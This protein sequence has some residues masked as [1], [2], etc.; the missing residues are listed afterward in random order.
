MH[1][2]KERENR[3][4][5]KYLGIDHMQEMEDQI[6][7]MP[8]EDSPLE[9]IV[10]W[11]NIARQRVDAHSLQLE[12]HI[13]GISLPRLR[14][15]VDINRFDDSQ[16]ELLDKH[17]IGL[18]I[19]ARIS[20]MSERWG[21]ILTDDYLIDLANSDHKLHDLWLTKKGD[22]VDRN[23]IMDM[24]VKEGYC[25]QL[26]QARLSKKGKATK[27]D[28]FEKMLQNILQKIA[29]GTI[30]SPK[31][32]NVIFQAFLQERD[33]GEFD[34]TSTRLK[35]NCPKSAELLENWRGQ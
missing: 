21:E 5:E 27:N 32:S 11:Y 24:F 22:D 1:K 2:F 8:E 33:S 26:Y 17:S 4:T 7:I 15:I 31:Q 29:R 3:Y 30:P 23:D 34:W 6:P 19:A 9:P 20:Q 28:R 13:F 12:A 18:N 10:S 25:G 14:N 35:K 16:I